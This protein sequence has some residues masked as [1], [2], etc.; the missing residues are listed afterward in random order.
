[1]SMSLDLFSFSDYRL[2]LKAWLEAARESRRSNLTLL[3][4]A[5]GVH[6][7]FL[8]HVL[9]GSKNLSF[10][11]V[12]ELMEPLGFTHLER[13]YFFAL[14][15]IE[16]AGSHK[17]KKYWND[18][19]S[20][21]IAEHQKLRS[22]VG[23]HHEL[24]AEDRAIFYSS[25]IYVAVFVATAIDD[26][27]RLE[28]IAERFH[29]SRDR[30]DEILNFLVQTGIC[31]LVGTTYK[32]GRSVVYL[33]NDSPLVVKHHT[34]WRMRAIQ[35][36]DSREDSELFFTSPMSMSKSDFLQIRELLAKA[37]QSTLAICKDSPAEEVVCLNIDLF[38]SKV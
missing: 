31:D 26:G 24:S 34:N 21:I 19:K 11:Q 2:Y 29:L 14:V 28:Q 36:M 32:M 7:S 1:M 4:K 16:R 6:T 22:R 17:L 10:E 12:T 9:S 5:I 30:A 33:T 38:R 18:K 27:Q 8:A 13:E 3:A 23:V 35:K 37:I 15:Q 20:E 25:W